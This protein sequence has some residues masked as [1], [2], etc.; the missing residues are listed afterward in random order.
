M[1]FRQVRNGTDWAAVQ[2]VSPEASPVFGNLASR[3][4]IFCAFDDFATFISPP[5]P[6]YRLPRHAPFQP[7][8][9]HFDVV[10]IC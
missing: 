4:L 8:T 10:I 9:G 1:M 3:S 6:P 5:R 2:L 7:S